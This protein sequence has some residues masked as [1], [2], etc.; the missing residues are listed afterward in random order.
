MRLSEPHQKE[1]V[2]I[3]CFIRYRID[4]T[5]KAEDPLGREN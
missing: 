5:K 2:M 1:P 4:P 3:T